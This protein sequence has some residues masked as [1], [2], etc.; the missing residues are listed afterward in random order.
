MCAHTSLSFS[1]SLL[2]QYRELYEL[3]RRRLEDQVLLVAQERDIWSSA[4]YDLALKVG[5]G[6]QWYTEGINRH[7]RQSCSKSKLHPKETFLFIKRNWVLTH[8][9]P[10]LPSFT[11]VCCIS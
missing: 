5:A 11:E 4:A 2:E 6:G 10:A 3:Q 8:L 1:S 7:S 9:I